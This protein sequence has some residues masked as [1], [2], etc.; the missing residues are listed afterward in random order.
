M[1]THA[2]LFFSAVRSRDFAYAYFFIQQYSPGKLALVFAGMLLSVFL[3]ALDQTILAP[4]EFPSK[5]NF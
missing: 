5:Q 4:G 1:Q 3:I 2:L